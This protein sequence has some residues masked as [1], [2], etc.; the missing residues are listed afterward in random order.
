MRI[1]MIGS[2]YV[3]LVTGACLA[4][5][6][7]RVTCVDKDL[8]RTASLQKN[9]MPF[10]EPG[11]AELVRE[12]A[13]NGS[14]DFSSS[15]S[16]AIG[17]SD[18]VFLAVGTP[19]DEKTGNADMSHFT[20]AARE[21]SGLLKNGALVVTKS[22][23]P[24]G[25]GARLKEIISSANPS[26]D[27]D[28]ASNPEFLR[29]GSA[30][31]DFLM[32]DRIVI[33]TDSAGARRIMD[34]IYSPF[35]IRNTPIFHT[36]TCTAELIKYA[37]NAFLAT[38]IA[39]INEMSDICEKTG[40]SVADLSEGMGLDSRIGGKFLQPG[41]GFGGSC[42]PKDTKALAAQGGSMGA[43]SLIVDAVVAA[44][45]KRKIAM[46]GKI[47]AALEE[48]RGS[49]AFLGLSFKAGTCDMRESPALIIIPELL[50]A[51]IKIRAYDPEA[52]ENARNL[53]PGEVEFCASAY[54]A[55][56]GAAALVVATEWPEFLELDFG[57][58]K[59]LLAAPVVVDLRNLLR[60]K[61]LPALG[62]SY[63]AIGSKPAIRKETIPHA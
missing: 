33:G 4:K 24:I 9:I 45:K 2:G 3:G 31:S 17:E 46:A 58:I 10:F 20:E 21:I 13:G 25:T 44:N 52:L 57:K 40:A 32:P 60:G 54:E 1:T 41:P 30:V 43:K 14:L 59:S 63:H 61:S 16:P 37:A 28:V 47:L 7:H 55:A 23:V 19:T 29:E 35:A 56:G 51:G 18:A 49:V 5:L 12:C 36:D 48:K 8:R 50:K 53:L 26:L 38:K 39:F 11:L 62:F 27:F 22:T 34:I 42:F 15:L 6:G